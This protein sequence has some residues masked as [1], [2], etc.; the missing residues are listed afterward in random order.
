[1]KLLTYT[2]AGNE[3][4]GVLKND[5]SEVVPV[6]YL[7]W[8]VAD[9]NEFLSCA[10]PEKLEKLDLSGHQLL[11]ARG[12]SRAVPR[13]SFRRRTPCADLFFQAGEPCRCGRRGN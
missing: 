5:G 3:A 12:G 2:Y 4:V 11:R 9:M 1:M 13:R 6:N 7:G 8:G 10:T